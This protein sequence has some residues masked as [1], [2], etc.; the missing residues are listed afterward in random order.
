MFENK[1]TQLPV[2]VSNMCKLMLSG[3]NFV[4]KPKS[5]LILLNRERMST[6]LCLAKLFIWDRMPFRF[7]AKAQ[8]FKKD[9][10]LED[11][12]LPRLKR[13]ERDGYVV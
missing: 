3:C 1:I 6:N 2:S 4:A 9:G 13:N 7:L 8:K 10:L 11:L 12:Q 5:M